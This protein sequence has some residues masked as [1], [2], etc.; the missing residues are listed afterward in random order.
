MDVG[1]APA[2]GINRPSSDQH[3]GDFGPLPGQFLQNR[4]SLLF[5]EASDEDGQRASGWQTMAA[6]H[7]SAIDA[8]SQAKNLGIDTVEEQARRV[9]RFQVG[10]RLPNGIAD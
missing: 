4:H 9:L 5:D 1:K 6:A 8:R 7:R 2:P 3:E 10:E